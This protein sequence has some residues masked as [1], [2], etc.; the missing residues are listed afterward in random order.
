MSSLL[1]L[2]RE[3]CRLKVKMI[4]WSVRVILLCEPDNKTAPNGQEHQSHI[5]DLTEVIVLEEIIPLPISYR[6]IPNIVGL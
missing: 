4:K 5:H 6:D 1:K 3:R 2:P